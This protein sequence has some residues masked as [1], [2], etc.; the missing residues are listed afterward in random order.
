M[1]KEY[2]LCAA[3]WYKE[4]QLK[5]EELQLKKEMPIEVYLP[6]NLDKGIVFSG[7][8]H[9]QCIYTKCVIT[10]LRDAESGENE[11]GFL[12]SKNRFVSR[13]EALIIALR[14][15]Q[16]IDLSQIRGD[17]LFSEDLY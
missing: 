8:R 1:D 10:G 9:G 14:E 6:K 2:I 17:R 12:T 11:Q 4:I 16:V 5:K 13:E 15:N 3:V 7:H